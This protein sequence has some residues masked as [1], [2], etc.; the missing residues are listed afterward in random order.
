[1]A[2]YRVPAPQPPPRVIPWRE[3]HWLLIDRFNKTMKHFITFISG[4]AG[5]GAVVGLIW[6]VGWVGRATGVFEGSVPNLLSGFL[7]LLML[8]TVGA[9]LLAVYGLGYLILEKVRGD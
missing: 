7:L 8:V 6:C 2:P 4:L 1:M 5:V 9:V 3:K